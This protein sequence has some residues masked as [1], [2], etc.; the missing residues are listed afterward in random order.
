ME[1]LQF[2]KENLTILIE[3]LLKSYDVLAC[4]YVLLCFPIFR[5]LTAHAA[6]PSKIQRFEGPQDF[7]GSYYRISK[8]S[9]LSKLSA[10]CAPGSL[11][12]KFACCLAPGLPGC[13]WLPAGSLAPWLPGCLG[14]WLHGSQA[15]C[16]QGGWKRSCGTLWIPGRGSQFFAPGMP[17]TIPRE[18]PADPG[19]G[20]Q[21]FLFF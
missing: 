2:S 17:E 10:L 3:S 6:D 18:N 8:L 19:L 20:R 12:P 7:C 11:D 14:L 21:L 9:E 4:S 13:G 15:A 5:S 16:P 1:I